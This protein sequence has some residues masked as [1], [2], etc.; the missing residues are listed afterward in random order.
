MI[1]STT[2]GQLIVESLTAVCVFVACKKLEN[3]NKV[4]I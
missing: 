1:T 4:F 3:N 2:G